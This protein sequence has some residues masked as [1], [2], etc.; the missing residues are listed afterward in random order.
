MQGWIVTDPQILALTSVLDD[1]ALV[2][3]PAKLMVH[4]AKDGLEGDVVNLIPPIAHETETGNYI[5]LGKKVTDQE[6]LTQMD[7]PGHETC[8]STL[9]IGS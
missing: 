5:V 6:A 1:E 9:L 2:E 7:T 4:L 8:V 3:V